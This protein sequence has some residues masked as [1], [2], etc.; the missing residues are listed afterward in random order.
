MLTRR[1]GAGTARLFKQS[2]AGQRQVGLAGAAL[3]TV[4][5]GRTAAGAKTADLLVN[6]AKRK[7][8]IQPN[9]VQLAFSTV[10]GGI[11]A[12]MREQLVLHGCWVGIQIL[13]RSFFSDQTLPADALH[14]IDHST[15][16]WALAVTRFWVKCQRINRLT[17]HRATQLALQQGLKQQRHN[18]HAQ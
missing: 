4:F 14:C 3:A 5:A 11:V 12:K 7:K 2:L 9:A 17:R 18:G 6:T 8:L 10:D 1:S 15:S 13:R 16:G